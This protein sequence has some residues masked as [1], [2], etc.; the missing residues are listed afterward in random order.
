MLYKSDHP[1]QI[2]EDG[3]SFSLIFHDWYA[4]CLC[5]SSDVNGRAYPGRQSSLLV[6]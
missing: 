5:H 3:R 6:H 2:K 4:L 1:M